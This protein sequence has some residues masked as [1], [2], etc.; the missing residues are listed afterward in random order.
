MGAG[1]A[2]ACEGISIRDKKLESV[3]IDAM[4]ERL[5]RPER[6]RGLLANLLDESSAAVRERQAHLKAPR[7]ERTRVERAIQNMLDFIEPGIVLRA[8]PTLP[9]VWPHSAPVALT[10]NRRSCWSR[11]SF[12]S[13]TGAS[14]QR[15]S[16]GSEM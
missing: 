12:R 7:T 6:P 16:N 9:P 5:L 1:R 14:R 4:A 15:Q 11:G 13:L 2:A 8:T 10:C 3:V